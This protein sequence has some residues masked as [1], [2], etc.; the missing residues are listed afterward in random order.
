M[1][2]SLGRRQTQQSA[3]Q[4][5]V[6]RLLRRHRSLSRADIAKR[7]GLSEASVSRT[8]LQLIKEHLVSEQ[9][10]AR[11]TGGRPAVLLQLDDHQRR[12]IGVDIHGWETRVSV[13]TLSGR[14]IENSYFKTPA[15]PMK[16]LDV[17]NQH[18]EQLRERIPDGGLDGV[19]VSCR[20]L[21][22]TRTGVVERGNDPAWW[23][24]PAREYLEAR[25]DIPA[26]IENNV[27][28]AALGE[29]HYGS[30]DV[31][32]AHCL[33]FVML[34][35]GIG[36]SLILKGEIFYGQHMSAGEFGQ[37]IIADRPGPE[38]HDRPG[39]LERLTANDAICDRYTANDGA[40]SLPGVKDVNS[41]VRQ[42]C[43]L[44]MAG[45][46]AA[47]D[48]LRETARYLGIGIANIVW[49]LDPDAVVIDGTCTDAWPL[50]APAIQDQFASERDFPSFRN[51][52]L[53]PSALRG[54]AAIIG[55]AALPFQRLFTEGND[56]QSSPR[57]ERPRTAV[58][59]PIPE[60]AAGD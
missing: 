47:V 8:V 24:I 4:A 50:I 3:H 15:D 16:T 39:C 42:I 49:G 48:T 9:G 34:D 53:R 54:E 7:S 36:V 26:H 14:I 23:R 17:V 2:D 25:L 52:V 27:R 38:R 37:M 12:S 56:S 40:A 21:V 41:C 35:E 1:A 19:G 13:A 33:L 60:T 31:Q 46:K 28:A 20:G 30:P 45:D 10:I 32:D 29:Y 58:P 43:H 44:A 59:S 55:A 57:G 51:L 18:V 5:M 6:L 22:N 11:T